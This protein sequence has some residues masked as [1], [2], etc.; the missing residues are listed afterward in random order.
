MR[1]CECGHPESDHE[2][3][4]CAYGWTGEPDEAPCECVGGFV[5]DYEIV[6]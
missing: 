2:M 4:D 6:E 1:V 5:L 3:V